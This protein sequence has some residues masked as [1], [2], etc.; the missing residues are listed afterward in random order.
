[1]P[2]HLDFKPIPWRA[3]IERLHGFITDYRFWLVDLLPDETYDGLPSLWL[4]G[5]DA[6]K[7]PTRIVKLITVPF[8]IPEPE[9]TPQSELEILVLQRATMLSM[10]AMPMVFE[11]WLRHPK[12]CIPLDGPLVGRD[13]AVESIPSHTF[14][15]EK[16]WALPQVLPSI[17][18]SSGPPS[19]IFDHQAPHDMDVRWK[20][21]DRS[22]LPTDMV[23]AWPEDPGTL[24][25][26]FRLE[27]NKRTPDRMLKAAL[28]VLSQLP[29]VMYHIYATGDLNKLCDPG[30]LDRHDMPRGETLGK[31][32]SQGWEPGHILGE[33]ESEPENDD[34]YDI[35]P[36]LVSRFRDM[37]DKEVH[38]LTVASW[39]DFSSELQKRAASGDESEAQANLT[40]DLLPVV[41]DARV[42]QFRPEVIHRVLG[43]V[44]A[45]VM[46]LTKFKE[47][48]TTDEEAKST[49]ASM[50]DVDHLADGIPF[51]EPLPFNNI[52]IGWG[53]GVPVHAGVG[54]VL[55]DMMYPP[56]DRPSLAPKGDPIARPWKRDANGLVIGYL[57]GILITNQGAEGRGEAYMVIEN[58]NHKQNMLVGLTRQ[59]EW[60]LPVLM[61]GPWL[62]A[63]LV[64]AINANDLVI[65]EK[66]SLS[67]RMTFQKFGKKFGKRPLPRPWYM[68][69]LH[70]GVLKVRKTIVQS[71]P[72][73][74]R[75]RWDVIGHDVRRIKRGDLPMSE[76]DIRDLRKRKYRIFTR[77]N[78]PDADALEVLMRADE[79]PP[80]DDEWVAV[81]K[82]WRRP[83]IKGP[84]DKPYVP[85]VHALRRKRA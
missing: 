48:P 53:P 7:E 69:T 61:Q 56:T 76:A 44:N 16:E 82:V 15:G 70:P 60:L 23:A 75:H 77:L 10:F 58:H 51:P 25:H 38:D 5:K 1:M 35:G 6:L 11:E 41:R 8:V 67:R 73:E 22:L 59:G 32:M 57:Q 27:W 72:R 3:A 2:T 50:R 65:D 63:W 55:T 85:S 54:L 81:Q 42:L 29:R 17:L 52:Y 31:I 74:W 26:L 62:L 24:K 21:G 19:L 49:A 39:L 46:K 84:G 20:E 66:H 28:L 34:E 30:L 79:P 12:G 78:P 71:M 40:N 68:V 36:A 45:Y 9:R 43:E 37:D 14:A 18:R 80:A 64:A 83:Y 47:E 33:P 4:A 13:F